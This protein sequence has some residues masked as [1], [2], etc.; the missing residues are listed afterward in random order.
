LTQNLH[1]N[2]ECR[3]DG[4]GGEGGGRERETMII[5]MK[6]NCRTLST[7]LL[8]DQTGYWNLCKEEPCLKLSISQKLGV[9]GNRA[10]GRIFLVQG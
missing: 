1:G 8:Q 9:F 6:I 10:M 2:A 3:W 5:T 7:D 4:E